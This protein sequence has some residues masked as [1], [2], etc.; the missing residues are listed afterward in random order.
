[1]SRFLITAGPTRE[2][3][4]TVRFLSN[5]SSGLT[6]FLMAEAACRAQHE[7]VLVSGPVSLPPPD[8]V[9]YI[10]VVSAQDMAREVLDRLP[11]ADVLIATAAVCDWRP[12]TKSPRKMAK[13]DRESLSLSLVRNPDI[14]F[15]AGQ[16]KGAR[17]HIGFA[18][19]DQ[20]P[21]G[22]ANARAKLA[23]KNLDFIVLN[24]PANMAR[25]H[26]DYQLI[27]K[28]GEVTEF[29]DITKAELADALVKLAASMDNGA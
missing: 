16:K 5:G 4:D 19:E 17:I 28:T 6:G 22:P 10:P 23:R 18:L 7:A 15:L 2:Y 13:G 14:L 27:S 25:Q 3:L 24:G 9:T 12:E 1:M 21:D 20:G 26:G 11:Q 29:Q 8:G